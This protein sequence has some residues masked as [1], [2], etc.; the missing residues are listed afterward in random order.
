[1][2][3][4][5]N[6]MKRMIE[7]EANVNVQYYYWNWNQLSNKYL[8]KFPSTR[9]HLSEKENLFIQAIVAFKFINQ[10]DK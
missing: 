2:I 8:L 1:M 4:S 3:Q 6:E 5:S 10:I 7:K 9:K